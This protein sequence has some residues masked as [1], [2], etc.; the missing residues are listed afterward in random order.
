MLNPS[1][2]L[3]REGTVITVPNVA[4]GR[5]DGQAFKIEVD[6]PAK[7]IR[8]LGRRDPAVPAA[9]LPAEPSPAPAAEP[10]APIQP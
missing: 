10:A 9:P 5:P 2:V 6:K 7:V 4:N 1:K 3:D 8:A